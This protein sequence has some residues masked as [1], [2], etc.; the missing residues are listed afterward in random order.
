MNIAYFKRLSCDAMGAAQSYFNNDDAMS[1]ALPFFSTG[2]LAFTD[3]AN[4]SWNLHANSSGLSFFTSNAQ[5]VA[6]SGAYFNVGSFTS[7]SII[8]GNTTVNYI[9]P[10]PPPLPSPPSPPPP[11]SPPTPPTPYGSTAAGLCS[12]SFR[13]N[14][15]YTF[16]I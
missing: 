1:P 5:I 2:G 10:N 6:S 16:D 3:S 13:Q 9:A 14:S 4:N 12:S 11:P 7:A 8:Y 15:M